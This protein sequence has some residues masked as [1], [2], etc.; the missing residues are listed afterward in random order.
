MCAWTQYRHPCRTDVR[1]IAN[2]LAR[3]AST[4]PGGNVRVNT[5]TDTKSAKRRSDTG[6]NHPAR[7]IH[8]NYTHVTLTERYWS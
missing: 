4:N 3:T 6:F 8:P 1:K 7:G 5:P 2:S